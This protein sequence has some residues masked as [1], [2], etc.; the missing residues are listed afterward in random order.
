MNRPERS[1][2]A[3]EVARPLARRA[4]YCRRRIRPD[5]DAEA[6]GRGVSAGAPCGAGG[7]VGRD[8]LLA[9]LGGR[10][11]RA[12]GVAQAAPAVLQPGRAAGRRR[13]VP[14][15]PGGPIRRHLTS[16]ETPDGRGDHGP[17]TGLKEILHLWSPD[18]RP[19]SR[20]PRPKALSCAWPSTPW[21]SASARLKATDE[22]H[23]LHHAEKP[24][25][26]QADR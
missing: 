25:G 3:G 4:G 7:E 18:W 20:P 9:G 2:R 26:P 17:E 15:D 21:P 8:V 14:F 23:L 6:A 5:Y 13:P 22:T 12:A 11:L 10:P 1:D 24:T 16:D 19:S